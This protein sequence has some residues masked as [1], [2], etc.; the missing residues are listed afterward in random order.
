MLLNTARRRRD[1]SSNFVKGCWRIW[2][3]QGNKTGSRNA[4]GN[5]PNVNW[6]D[7]KLNVNWTNPDNQNDNLRSR[8][9][10]S[11]KHLVLIRLGVFI[12]YY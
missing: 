1:N 4:D 8:A 5:V 3:G 2:T 11:E 7:D 10:V 12:Y 9:E 6:N